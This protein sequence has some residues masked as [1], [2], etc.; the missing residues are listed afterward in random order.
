MGAVPE[1]IRDI[2]NLNVGFI[3]SFSLRGKANGCG[4]LAGLDARVRE[5]QLERV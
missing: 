5:R 1:G 4:K 2:S 3:M